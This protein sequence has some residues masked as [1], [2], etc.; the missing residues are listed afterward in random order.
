[1]KRF[2]KSKLLAL[3]VSLCCLVN[4][5]VQSSLAYIVATTEPAANTF[6]PFQNV[7]G[8]LILSKSVDHPF[9]ADYVIP[10]NIGFDFEI[11]LGAA[12][13]G[14]TLTST[15]G[16][17]T[18]DKNGILSVHVK[19][20]VPL[21]IEGIDEGT[22]VTITEI[23]KDGDGFE[24][25]DGTASMKVTID[26]EE[27]AIT[28][29]INVY[30]PAPVSP[31]QVTLTGRKI[32]E[33]RNWQ[34]GDRFCFLLERQDADGNWITMGT[35]E[36]TYDA[37]NADFDIFDFS[38]LIQNMEFT[39]IGTYSF[40]VTEENGSLENMVYDTSEKTFDIVVYDADMDGCLEIQE[41]TSASLEAS[42]GVYSIDLTF[43]NAYN[44]ATTTTTTTTTT[45]P[46][47]TTITSTT[48][49]ESAT[50]SAATAISTMATT[51]KSTTTAETTTTSKPV[52]TTTSTTAMTERTT[53]GTTTVSTIGPTTPT[54]TSTTTSTTAT[55][56]RTTTGTTTVSTIGPT[57]PTQTSTTTSTTATTERTTT[58]TTTV[59]TI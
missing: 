58:G 7:E 33:G 57:T 25:M 45:T 14:Y 35:K 37:A 12:Y 4:M 10:E 31:E 22:E 52:T 51:T 24:V 49:T 26:S 43:T 13:A 44:E 48:I 29:F 54:Q 11:R 23:Q 5:A 47:T 6:V 3:S 53:T 55:T 42:T 9:G 40:R 2:K 39:E 15:Q 8:D 17:I 21:G 28:P 30:T 16:D 36:V 18:A 32:L 46:T 56:E 1:M 41:V 34:D 20:G 19:P 38:S 50:T 27:K 59:S